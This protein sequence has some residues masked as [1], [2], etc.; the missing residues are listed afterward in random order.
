M[1]KLRTYLERL[2]HDVERKAI[3]MHKDLLESFLKA[4]L[5]YN[6]KTHDKHKLLS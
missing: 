2:I 6:Q 5:I 4:K 1:R 3:H